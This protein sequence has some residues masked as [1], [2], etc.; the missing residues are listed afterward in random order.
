MCVHRGGVNSI[1]LCGAQLFILSNQIKR[2]NK[3]SNKQFFDIPEL[4]EA[5]EGEEVLFG[6]EYHRNDTERSR[7]ASAF[8]WDP[9]FH[10]ITS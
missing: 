9:H 6:L 10:R 4:E 5:H 1:P 3:T 8:G 7:Q 2:N